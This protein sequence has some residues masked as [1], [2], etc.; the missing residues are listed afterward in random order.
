MSV[1]FHST[2]KKEELKKGKEKCAVVD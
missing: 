2:Q 1:H